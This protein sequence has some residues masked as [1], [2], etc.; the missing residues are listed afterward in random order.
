MDVVCCA[1]GVI[2]LRVYDA[3]AQRGARGACAARRSAC[4]QLCLPV[5]ETDSQCRCAAGYSRKGPDCHREY[6]RPTA[7]AEDCPDCRPTDCMRTFQP[8]TS[9]WCTP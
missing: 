8:S 2:S 4:S 6:A 9:W 1:E 3:E 7:K 5:S